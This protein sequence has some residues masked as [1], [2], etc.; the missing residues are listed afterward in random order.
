MKVALIQMEIVQGDIE[1]NLAKIGNFVKKAK[2]KRADIIV[3]PEYCLTGSVRGKPH[4]IDSKGAYRKIF[5]LLAKENK[6]DI[7]AGS[8]IEKARGKNYNTSCYFDKSGKLLGAYRKINLWH[9]ERGRLACGKAVSV[10]NTRFGK[11]GIAVCWDLSDPIIF[12]EM[13]GKGARIIYVPSFWS[14]AGISNRE[15]E[16]KNIGALCHA[17]AF[18]SESAIIYVNAAGEYGP[19]DNLIGCSQ[20]AVPIKG[21]VKTVQHSRECMMILDVPLKLLER[22][23]KVYKIRKDI[24]QGYPK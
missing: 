15:I 22:A 8:F 20:L 23:A 5:S 14:D 7:V 3:F 13:A 24:L 16:S 1:A 10:F 6:I 2:S 18:E 12:R 9:S 17:R 19:G 11:T 21:A 4:L